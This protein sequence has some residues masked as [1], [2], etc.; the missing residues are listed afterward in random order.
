M[1]KEDFSM[2]FEFVAG[3]TS[4]GREDDIHQGSGTASALILVKRGREQNS[5]D[6]KSL[7]ASAQS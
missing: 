5:T 4:E 2:Q 3:E 6:K 1:A 7:A